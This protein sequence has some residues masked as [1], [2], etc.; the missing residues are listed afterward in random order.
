MIMYWSA[1][2]SSTSPTVCV[3]GSYLPRGLTFGPVNGPEDFQG[4]VFEIFA[5]RLYKDHFIFIDDLAVATGRKPCRP[6]GPSQVADVVCTL[7]CEDSDEGR[8]PSGAA[9]ASR[10]A[11]KSTASEEVQKHESYFMNDS[12]V[13]HLEDSSDEEQLL[14]LVE[15]SYDSEG[16]SSD[17][18][19]FQPLAED[20]RDLM[21]KHVSKFAGVL[22]GGLG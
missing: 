21:E 4:L 9:L 1:I 8:L 16:D 19:L 12:D 22:G 20:S 18:E 13:P 10:A 6:P 2:A 15:D 3:S 17:E 7:K 14:S 11:P 5:R